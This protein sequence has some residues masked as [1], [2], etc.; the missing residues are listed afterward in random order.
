[1]IQ[2]LG[3]EAK[4]RTEMGACNEYFRKKMPMTGLSDDR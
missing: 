3:F 4:F 2:T 1:M